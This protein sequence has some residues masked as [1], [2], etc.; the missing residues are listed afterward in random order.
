[1][2][3]DRDGRVVPPRNDENSRP[4]HSSAASMT[5]EGS[6]DAKRA[7]FRSGAVHWLTHNAIADMPGPSYLLVYGILV[8]ITIV[9]VR[10]RTRRLDPSLEL[11]PP[12]VPGRLSAHQIAHLRGGAPRVLAVVLYD[13]CRRGYLQILRAG[14]RGPMVGRSEGVGQ[15]G[16][17]SDFERAV[18]GEI[19]IPRPVVELRKDGRLAVL[20][21]QYCAKLEEPLEDDLL[22]MPRQCQTEALGVGWAAAVCLLILA[23]YKVLV[24]LAKGRQNVGFLIV[25]GI[26]GAIAVM[27]AARL[28]RLTR[29]GKAYLDRLCLAF[30]NWPARIASSPD[31]AADPA[32][33]MAIALL[34]L[35]ALAGTTLQ[36]AW[37]ELMPKAESQRM[38]MW[39]RRGCGGRCGCGG[40]GGCGG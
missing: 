11:D 32:A 39:W 26:A 21:E 5:P 17:L 16:L 10:I 36:A 20:T 33:V 3:R 22:L 13:L 29:Q 35:P 37:Q 40:C 34:G 7:S 2:N 31:A 28:P 1:M 18:F 14:E 23:I 12:T 27:V 25:L 38:R 30:E 15:L 19:K 24:A 6:I 8:L 9:I 4:I